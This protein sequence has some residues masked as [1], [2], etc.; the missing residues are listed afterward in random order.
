MDAYHD[1]GNDLAVAANGDLMPV[2]GT[3]ETRQ[4]ALRRILTPVGGYLW[5]QEYGAG[6]PGRVGDTLTPD[7]FGGIEADILAACALESGIASFP[8]PI[9]DLQLITNGLSGNVTYFDAATK[10]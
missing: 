7:E 9:V 1:Y 6:V 8:A 3:G 2:D 5:N 4:R 10:T